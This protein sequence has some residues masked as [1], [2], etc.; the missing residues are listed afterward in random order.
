[1]AEKALPLCA[2][3]IPELMERYEKAARR[4]PEMLSQLQAHM[5]YSAPF[6]DEFKGIFG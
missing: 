6:G 3:H 2:P 1:M 4:F 5:T